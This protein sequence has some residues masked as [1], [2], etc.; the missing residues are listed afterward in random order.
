MSEHDVPPERQ[1]KPSMNKQSSKADA[2]KFLQNE[3]VKLEAKAKGLEDDKRAL[4][5]EYVLATDDE[6]PEKVKKNI[7]A[8]MPAALEAIDEI[9][10]TGSDGVRASLAKWIVDRGLAPDALGGETTKDRELAKLLG[11]LREDE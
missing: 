6:A 5:S 7:R 9:L 11:E 3:I 4:I 2:A 10:A 1:Q 8:R